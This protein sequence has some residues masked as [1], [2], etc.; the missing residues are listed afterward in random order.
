M[1]NLLM[2]ICIDLILNFKFIILNYFKEILFG[3]IK[4]INFSM[5]TMQTFGKFFDK[6]KLF[7]QWL[8]AKAMQSDA[9]F[10]TTFF[11]ILRYI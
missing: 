1:V 2:Q 9:K 11:L 8:N 5:Q 3:N 4:K 10:S 7:L 6:N